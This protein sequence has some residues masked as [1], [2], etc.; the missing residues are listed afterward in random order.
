MGVTLSA[1]ELYRRG[2]VHLNAGQNAAAR[3]DLAR[4]AER[5]GDADLRAR[6]AG[7]LAAVV[8]R[9]GDPAAAEQLCRAALAA[10]ALST[11]TAAMLFGQLG[12]LALERGDLDEAVSWLDR[13]IAGIG[14]SREHRTP[15]LVNRSVAHMLAGRLDAARAD[16]E[17]SADSYAQQGDDIERA[18]AVHN[19]GY[20]ALLEGDLIR[21]LALMSE[22]RP[23]MEA[24]SPVNGA[25][26][27]VDRAEVL[28]DAGLVTEAEGLLERVARVFGAHNMRQARGEAEFS[29]AR[30]L[31][32]HDPARAAAVA[33]LAARRFRSLGSATWAARSEGIRMRAAL[34]AGAIGR[35]GNPTAPVRAVPSR[36]VV[37]VTAKEL[38]RY[39]LRSD[40][41]ALRLTAELWAARNTSGSGGPS[42]RIPS[43]RSAP[44]EVTLLAHE[45]RAARAERSADEAEVRRHAAAGLD[46]A[47]AWHS[48]FGSLDL[49]TSTRMRGL[50]LTLVGLGSAMRSGRP[51]VM[52]EWSERVR[53]FNQDVTPLRPP[54]DPE[55]ASVLARLRM[56]RFENPTGDWLTEPDGAV[57]RDRAR[58]I[59]WS[60]T[61]TGGIEERFELDDFRSRLDVDTALL[62]YNFTGDALTCLVVTAAGA[63]LASIG[64]WPSLRVALAGLRADLDVSATVR[65]GPMA[66]VVERT[67]DAR[68]AALSRSLVDVPMA[69]APDIRRFV[70]TA[71]GVLNGVPWAMFPALRGRVFTVA[72]S[73]TRW[74]RAREADSATTSA[75]AV[76][77]AVGPRVARGDEEVAV[78]ASAWPSAVIRKDAD[79]TVAA[80]TAIAGQV[81]V[82]HVAAHG[83][84]AVDNP[85]FSGL[86]LAD[87]TLFGYDIDLVPRVPSTVVLSACELGRSSVRWGEEAIG[88]TRTWLHAGT[89]TVIAAPVV[90]ADDVACELLGELH[91]GLVAG[92]A[93]AEALAGATIAT[94]LIAPFHCSGVGF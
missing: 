31:L 67:R 83:R 68:L 47:S 2:R 42:S 6:I 74:A 14:D 77:F 30:S 85:L 64:S 56:R 61:G 76:G 53:H 36:E 4:A 72:T 93:P 20:I 69:L 91:T 41:T 54:A 5:T 10:P 66:A 46:A 57:L 40:A 19:L 73:A 92:L 94:G 3:R 29:L 13:G 78:A 58:E 70:I 11:E 17:A 60:A 89:Q 12:L 75:A 81:D 59:Q 15:M 80:I 49:Q 43:P 9:Q 71:P 33:S 22:A 25:I 44:L 8:I 45:V 63:Q 1:Q 35:S 37:E 39:G 62:A 27:A 90:V 23:V 34:S 55:L 84:H 88:M 24:A 86:E 51:D 87:G 28:R 18:M 16:G 65:S 52:F 32:T 7:S 21:G 38:D 26:S 48:A 50:G 82:L 79:A